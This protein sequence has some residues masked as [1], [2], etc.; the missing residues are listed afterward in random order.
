MTADARGPSEAAATTWVCVVGVSNRH[1]LATPEASANNH[2]NSTM[3]TVVRLA[4]VVEKS[5]M[6]DANLKVDATG[7]I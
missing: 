2:A 3:A 5:G 6:I 7:A 4:K 1:A